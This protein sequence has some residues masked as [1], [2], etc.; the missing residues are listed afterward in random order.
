MLNMAKVI[1]KNSGVHY[2]TVIRSSSNELFADEPEN[3]GGHDEG[4]S[5]EEL[6]ASALASCTCITLRMYADRKKWK[7]EDVEAEVDFSFNNELNKSTIQ[8]KIKLTGDLS[9]AEKKRLYIIAEKCFVH[10]V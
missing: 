7:L 10:K 2:K 3:N 4:F 6:L 1:A 5:P 8:R 9:E